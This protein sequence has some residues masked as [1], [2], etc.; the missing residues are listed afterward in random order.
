MTHLKRHYRTHLFQN[1]FDRSISGYRIWKMS[2]TAS[3][4]QRL[5]K[6]TRE[7]QL[8]H[9]RINTHEY[10]KQSYDFTFF[11][12]HGQESACTQSRKKRLAVQCWFAVLENQFLMQM[13]KIYHEGKYKKFKT[14]RKQGDTPSKA[15]VKTRR[16]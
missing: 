11:A 1:Y 4:V 14:W 10:K 12:N 9:P 16:M 7:F 5:Q 15:R 2:C 8:I 6:A 13:L 3:T